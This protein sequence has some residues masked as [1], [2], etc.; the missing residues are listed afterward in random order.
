M[1]GFALFQVAF[2]LAC[3]QM[4]YQLVCRPSRNA[5]I[6]DIL[7]EVESAIPLRNIGGQRDGSPPNLRSKVIPF[8]VWKVVDYEIEPSSNLS[9]ELPDFKILEGCDRTA[10]FRLMLHLPLITDH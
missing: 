6:L 2:I 9:A 3:D 1:I 4:V 7:F 5:T 10:P 8:M